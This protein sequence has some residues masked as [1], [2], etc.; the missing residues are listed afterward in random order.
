MAKRK[1]RSNRGF[2]QKQTT[3]VSTT[4]VEIMGDISVVEENT[5]VSTELDFETIE[6]KPS[7][8]LEKISFEK[9][10]IMPQT[11]IEDIFDIDDVYTN[12][13][14]IIDNPVVEKNKQFI[15]KNELLNNLQ[16][17]NKVDRTIKNILFSKSFNELLNIVEFSKLNRNFF[18]DETTDETDIL[19]EEVITYFRKRLAKVALS[20]KDYQVID[21]YFESIKTLYNRFKNCEGASKNLLKQELEIA[22]KMDAYIKYHFF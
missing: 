10:E 2:Q 7:K 1:K 6:R 16:F 20:Y 18:I 19:L 5:S 8:E 22:T 13:I 17:K 9:I 15:S 12:Q 4:N 21:A 11:Y 3:V 14:K